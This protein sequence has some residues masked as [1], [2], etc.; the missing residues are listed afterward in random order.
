M[1]LSSC[2]FCY[3]FKLYYKE[4][5]FNLCQSLTLFTKKNVRERLFLNKKQIKTA[6]EPVTP[7][8][9]RSLFVSYLLVFR[10][11]LIVGVSIILNF[12]NFYC[13]LISAPNI[14]C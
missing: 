5:S 6:D 7:C 13:K 4:K 8:T 14:G 12:V 9:S 11:K 10:I 1:F 2:T 3:S